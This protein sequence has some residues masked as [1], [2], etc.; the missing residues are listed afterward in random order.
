[1]EALNHKGSGEA[2]IHSLFKI[3]NHDKD[4]LEFLKSTVS[5]KT[6]MGSLL[7]LALEI[8]DDKLFSPAE[9]EN[10][11][12]ETAEQG[13]F[14]ALDRLAADYSREKLLKLKSEH[15]YPPILG[16]LAKFEDN[17]I[18]KDKLLAKA[19]DE[20]R[21]RSFTSYMPL[22]TDVP[23]YIL[24]SAAR[25]KYAL[26]NYVEAELFYTQAIAKYSL[27]DTP[28]DLLQKAADNKIVLGKYEE[29]A[30]LY[31][32]VLLVDGDNTESESLGTE[33][34]EKFPDEANIP[35]F[36]LES[37]AFHKFTLDKFDEADA[38]YTRAIV[39]AERTERS[40]SE[41]VDQELSIL[42]KR[43]ADNKF[44]MGK[45]AEAEAFYIRAI[46]ICPGNLSAW[47][48]SEVVEKYGEDVPPALLLA[49][50]RVKSNPKK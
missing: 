24:E 48:I 30:H 27:D 32:E 15:P 21:I 1:M 37:I 47:I 3:D 46:E 34:M 41:A 39:K 40:T 12:L 8:E 43:T 31:N 5:R 10:L 29:A 22:N 4:A 13:D 35:G 45:S 28:L 18:E 26:G 14:R 33:F 6:T 49:V 7:A 42:L 2:L 16:N 38:L 19:L 25:N 44:A 23:K 36:F 11:A 9:I 50:A 20:Y 17:L